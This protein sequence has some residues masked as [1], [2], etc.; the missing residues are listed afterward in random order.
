MIIALLVLI[1]LAILFPGLLRAAF[2]CVAFV[3]LFAIGSAHR[4]GAEELPIT[5]VE[6]VCAKRGEIVYVN[7]CI[8]TEQEAYDRLRFEWPA[9]HD[10]RQAV[11]VAEFH[12][13]Y[14]RQP[15]P[16]TYLQGCVSAQLLQQEAT[17]QMTVRQKFQP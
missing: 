4:A 16:L 14:I 5:D 6:A 2:V 12:S 13:T 7:Q 8:G 9:L 17:E 1:L 11:C 3:V 10:D 15:F